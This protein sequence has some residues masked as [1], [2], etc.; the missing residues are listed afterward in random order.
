MAL[1][2]GTLIHLADLEDPQ[3]HRFSEDLAKA[4]S[5]QKTSR[6]RSTGV[7]PDYE[8]VIKRA[9]AILKN[10]ITLLRSTTSSTLCAPSGLSRS[11]RLKS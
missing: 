9:F 5:R 2:V 11:N 4:V 7:N 10:L 6:F 1:A 3:R 8:E